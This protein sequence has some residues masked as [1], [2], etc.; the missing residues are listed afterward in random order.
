MSAVMAG[1]ALPGYRYHLLRG[2]LERFSKNLAELDERQMAVARAQADKTWGLESLVLGS[3]EASEI[4]IPPE[5]VD[6]AFAE[7]AGRYADDKALY[8]DLA[9]NGLDE[10]RLRQA[11]YRELVFDSVMQRVA[12]R[13]LK[14]SQIDARLYYELHP[15]KFSQPEQRTARQ[16]LITIN[17]D[18]VE[19]T[20]SA[21][22]AR[23]GSIAAKL[24]VSPNRFAD[25]A[26]KHSECPSA[27][28]GG[29]LG[30]VS[31]GQLYPELDS[32]LFTLR[33]GEISDVLET[34]VGFHLLWC[35]KILPA[36]TL[37]F[38]RSEDA[39]RQLLDK[40]NQRNC[41]KAWLKRLKADKGE[42]VAP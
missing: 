15:E 33:E 28:D 11:L 38:S 9:A 39:I 42:E 5:Q 14:V 32:V 13:R 19:N 29:K 41:Q 36:R 37:P 30:T 7:V 2:A 3:P 27:L 25:Q 10:T 4:V 31:R 6:M 17:D 23:I 26:R 18:F 16:I 21:A 20:R 8:A 1:E 12:A 34:E 40:R 24:A 22:R 35:E